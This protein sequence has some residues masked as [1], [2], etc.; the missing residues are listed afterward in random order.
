MR[1][2]GLMEC[3]GGRK[4]VYK[5]LMERPDGTRQL[6]RPRHRWNYNIKTNLQEM[7]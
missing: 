1:W 2:L 4:F 3:R 6:V 7:G 5:D